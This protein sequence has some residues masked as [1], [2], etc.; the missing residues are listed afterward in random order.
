MQV[1]PSDMLPM[2]AETTIKDIVLAVCKNIDSGAVKASSS[3]VE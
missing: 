3:K 2:E 1:I